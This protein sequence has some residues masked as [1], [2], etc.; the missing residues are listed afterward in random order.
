MAKATAD[1]ACRM[2]IRLAQSQRRNYEKAADLRGQTLSRWTTMHLDEH[3]RGMGLDAQLLRD[4]ILNSLKVSELAGA[5][6]LVVDP[7]G[8]AASAFCRRFG[9]SDLLGTTRMVLRLI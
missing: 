8:E 5:R 4:A 1:K 3:C 2:D 6:A 7:A 9:F